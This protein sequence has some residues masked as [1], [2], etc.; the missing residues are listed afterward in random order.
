MDETLRNASTKSV[1]LAPFNS[2]I[3][4]SSRVDLAAEVRELMAPKADV[5]R[6]AA[7]CRD[8]D[9][10]YEINNN[11]ELDNGVYHKFVYSS[12]DG[13]NV[14]I[15]DD[16]ASRNDTSHGESEER[17]YGGVRKRIQSAK[18]DRRLKEVTPLLEESAQRVLAGED[19]ELEDYGPEFASFASQNTF[20]IEE[21]RLNKMVSLG[22]DR[23]YIIRCLTTNQNN[24]CTSGYYLLGTDQNYEL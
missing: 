24:Y 10:Q 20:I 12:G 6:F 17:G 23:D 1:I 22:Y 5:M 15:S 16:E 2:S 13:D 19:S 11:C 3:S 18:Q 4:D 21:E 14:P 7:R 9:R 8:Q